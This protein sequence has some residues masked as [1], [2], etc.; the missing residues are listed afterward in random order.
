MPF[1][2]GREMSMGLGKLLY[3]TAVIPRGTNP[4]SSS[5]LRATLG[6]GCFGFQHDV[7]SREPSQDFHEFNQVDLMGIVPVVHGTNVYILKY[8]GTPSKLTCI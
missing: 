2:T 1:L 8:P 4:P 6:I 3:S 5:R 7:D